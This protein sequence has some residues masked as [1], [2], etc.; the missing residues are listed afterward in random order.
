M[1]EGETF[2]IYGFQLIRIKPIG[3][4]TGNNGSVEEYQVN[5]FPTNPN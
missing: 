2:F 5:E 1:T 3:G 4:V